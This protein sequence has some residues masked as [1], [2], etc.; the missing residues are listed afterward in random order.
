MDNCFSV[1]QHSLVASRALFLGVVPWDSLFYINLPTDIELVQVFLR[2]SGFGGTMAE[3]SLS[4]PGVIFGFC[5]FVCFLYCFVLRKG[6]SHVSP[7]VSGH[8]L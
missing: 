2:Q 4:F 3:A 1:S 8:S 6:F 7:F 5:L